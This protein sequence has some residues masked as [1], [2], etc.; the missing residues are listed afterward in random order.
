MARLVIIY[1]PGQGLRLE[2][3]RGS[4]TLGRDTSNDFPIEDP[5]VSSRHCEVEVSDFS[6]FVRDLGSTNGTLI[7]GKLVQEGE[8]KNGQKLRLGSVE[9]RLEVTPP[10]IAIP[11]LPQAEIPAPKTLPDGRPAC[12]N[13]A[14]V[15]AVGRCAQCTRSFCEQCIHELRM[16]GGRSRWFCPVCSGACQLFGA[17]PPKPKPKALTTRLLETIRIS[18]GW[19]PPDKGGSP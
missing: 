16:V 10:R 12:F 1:G 4:N 18:L 7:E 9:M 14:D 5:T 8:L 19:K 13:H 3:Q 6:V 15:P 17:P 11:P 2:L